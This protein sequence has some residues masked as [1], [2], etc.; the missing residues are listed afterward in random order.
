M[1][2]ILIVEDDKE[3]SLLFQKVLE[4]SG[5]QVK[6][7]SDGAQ[8]LEVLDRDSYT[9]FRAG[10][11]LPAYWPLAPE[12]ALIALVIWGSLSTVKS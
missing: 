12:M 5:Y 11:P 9:V 1:F 4:K 8:A 2:K 3:L 10:S 7:A 6:S